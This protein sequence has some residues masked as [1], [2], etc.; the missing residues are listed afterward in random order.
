[1]QNDRRT[2]ARNKFGYFMTVVAN[3][4]DEVVGYLSDI[5]P[6]GFRLDC[7]KPLEIG[8]DYDLRLDLTAEIA[9]VSSI[10]FVARALWNQP[11]PINPNEYVQ[12]FQ[13]ISISPPDEEIFL[14]IVEK[15]G[16]S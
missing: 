8:V 4:T 11:D 6:R 3:K 15:Y 12:G 1:M 13:L 2:E 7:R 5:S 10:F 14:R 16:R 9:S